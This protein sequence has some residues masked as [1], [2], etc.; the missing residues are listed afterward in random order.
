MSGSPAAYPTPPPAAQSSQVSRKRVRDASTEAKLVKRPRTEAVKAEAVK[1][2]SQQDG[3]QSSAVAVSTAASTSPVPTSARVMTVGELRRSMRKWANE[4]G[5]EYEHAKYMY[6]HLSMEGNDFASLRNRDKIEKAVR[7]YT[8]EYIGQEKTADYER[9]LRISQKYVWS[10]L[11][12]AAVLRNSDVREIARLRG[13]RA[14][15]ARSTYL[16]DLGINTPQDLKI[17]WPFE[18]Q[19]HVKQ[20]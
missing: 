13:T 14:I 5:L 1:A 10:P 4:R 8:G 16:R 17:M 18:D 11:Q 15:A 19:E 6:V 9:A 7:Y 20:S 3:R 2:A 12:D